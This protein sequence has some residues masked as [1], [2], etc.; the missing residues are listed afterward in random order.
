TIA[1]GGTLT[2]DNQDTQS[3]THSITSD[4]IGPNGK[5]LFDVVVA[6]GQSAAVPISGLGGGPPT[7]PCKFPAGMT[8][9][10]VLD[11]PPGRSITAAPKFEQPLV[12]PPRLRGKHLTI[13]MRKAKVRVLP[14]GPKTPM[15]TFGG[16]FPGPTIVRP[17]GHDTKVTFVNHLPRRIGAVTIHQH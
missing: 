17:T 15:M 11:G 10:L 5:P 9:T 14:H 13:V 8:G 16:T 12:Q 3:L 7:F 6:A 4:A 2:I 1:K